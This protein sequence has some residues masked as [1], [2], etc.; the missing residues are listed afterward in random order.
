M[1][2]DTERQSIN[3]T[4]QLNNTMRQSIVSSGSSH[5]PL[6]TVKRHA[7]RTVVGLLIAVKLPLGK[8]PTVWLCKYETGLF[9]STNSSPCL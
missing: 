4:Y 5:G 1:L 7:S 9:I 3:K 8:P 6:S 2:N